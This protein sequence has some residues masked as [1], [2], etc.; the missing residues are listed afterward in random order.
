MKR[1][2][3]FG[4]MVL[5][6]FFCMVGG[7]CNSYTASAEAADGKVKV[8]AENGKQ[9]SDF[10]SIKA[11]MKKM[12]LKIVSTAKGKGSLSYFIYCKNS[13][14]PF[15]YYVK[16]GVLHLEESGLELPSRKELIQ[17]LG[18]KGQNYFPKVTVYV[19]EKTV[20]KNI[21]VPYVDL[22]LGKKA[23]FANTQIQMKEGD[24]FCKGSSI[25][26][27][28]KI[29]L[30]DGDF[31]GGMLNVPGNMEIA[32]KEGDIFVTGLKVSGDLK[33]NCNLGDIF[34]SKVD[35]KSFDAMSVTAT[36]SVGDMFVLG[37]MKAGKKKEK[38]SGYYYKKNG[39]GKGKFTII[40][41]LGDIFLK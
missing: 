19:P 26:G 18:K 40:T 10:H 12:D 29:S 7:F 11:D 8:F 9:I 13:K 22:F 39:T 14:N 25:T 17:K 20:I 3:R 23:H 28:V 6:M 16:D 2:K 34:V 21:N 33:V 1:V 24:V 32:A 36:T 38:G 31:F 41:E 27:T 35:K 37:E 30:N 4:F 5:I 15:S